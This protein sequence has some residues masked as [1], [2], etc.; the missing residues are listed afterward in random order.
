MNCPSVHGTR[1]IVEE[2]FLLT[3]HDPGLSLITFSKGSPIQLAGVLLVLW[4][5]VSVM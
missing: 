3:G 2:W 5:L 1:S 4:M